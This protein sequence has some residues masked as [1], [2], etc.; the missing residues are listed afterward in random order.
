MSMNL[1]ERD[2]KILT[3]L[4]VVAIL[5]LAYFLGFKKLNEKRN[6][7]DDE[8]STLNTTYA[9]LVTM[10]N[11]AQKYAE[12]AEYYN[13]QYEELMAKY[14]TGYSQ[15][16]TIDFIN[17]LEDA[18]GAWISQAGLAQTTLWYTFGKISSSNPYN[19]GGS[20]Y[21]TDNA[22][23]GTTLSLSYEASYE[24]FKNLIGYI[25]NYQY[26]CTITSLASTYN[27]DSDVV[28]G[29]MTLNTYAITGSEREFNAGTY[30]YGMYGTDNIFYS[31]IFASGAAAD[32]DSG[33][34]II[35]DYDFYVSVDAQP[36][37]DEEANIVVDTKNDS[38]GNNAI[39]ANSS[40]KSKTIEINITG[41]E[42]D[43]YVS[44]KIGKA[45]FPATDYEKGSKFN[46]GNILS[47]L[48][49]SS[50]RVDSKDTAGINLEVHNDTDM[51]L[52]IK[53]VGDD[54]SDPRVTITKSGDVQ[55][56]R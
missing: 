3:L 40:K 37:D 39:A 55:I 29:S 5:A 8:I 23:Y 38:A 34:N 28:S 33:N 31:E 47:L 2:K 49:V 12:D 43:Y 7:L 24:D 42:G 45:K 51:T 30:K 41:E 19:A 44:Y 14:D 25:N 16:H 10:K 50:E 9:N 52:Q 6:D 11:N 13:E 18:T 46:V 1:T 26:K 35:S 21:Y 54:E 22:A 36:E 53:V 20:V 15:Q 27:S 17:E 4:I 32:V 56:F 48:V